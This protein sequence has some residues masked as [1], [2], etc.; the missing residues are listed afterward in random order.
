MYTNG[1]LL[2]ADLVKKL[3]DAGLNEIRFDLSAVAYDLKKVRLAVGQIPIVTVEIPA[4]SKYFLLLRKL[5]PNLKAIGVDHLNLHQLRLNPFNRDQLDKRNYTYLH[6]EKVTVLESEL[7]ALA[8]MQHVMDQNI[9]LPV[10]YCASVFQQ[11]FQR[12]AARRKRARLMVKPHE[13]ITESGYIRSLA[14]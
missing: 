6:G 4:I 12:A 13:S 1:T 14:S 9:D 5:L 7:T 11:R 2:T 10:N 8:L 3:R